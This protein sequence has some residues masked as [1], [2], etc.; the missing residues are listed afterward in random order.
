MPPGGGAE[1]IAVPHARSA[2]FIAIGASVALLAL[3][4]LAAPASAGNT[5]TLY[6][7]SP[8]A[9]GGTGG[10][11]T[12]T[13]GLLS[14]DL[15]AL[16]SVT[17]GGA[18]AVRVL[19]RN[20]GNQTLN[21]LAFIGG[22]LA[23]NAAYNTLYPKPT[24]NS[25]DSNLSF[26]AVYP[27][28]GA[29]TCA[30]VEPNEIR[31]NVGTL[32]SGDAAAYLVVIKTTSAASGALPFWLTASWNEG[33]STTGN[34]ADYAFAE[35]SVLVGAAS[36]SEVASY[37]LA[38]ANVNITNTVISGCAQQTTITTAPLG[39][40]GTFANIKVG[41]ATPCAAVGL[42]CFGNDSTVSVYG[43][44]AVAG[45]IEWTMRWE[46][47][48]INGKPKGVVHFLDAYYTGDSSAW[49]FISFNRQS[50]CKTTTSTDCWTKITSTKTYFEVTFRTAS[51]GGARGAY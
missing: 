9:D 29:P 27:L 4:T 7:G 30:T 40:V 28:D 37:F 1:V 39:G 17:A 21:K 23:D 14:G 15:V 33:W 51:N 35:G 19:L 20:D 26:L 12:A 41:G 16:N 25:L 45:G 50:E 49:V 8:E 3:A 42:R 34:N 38:N 48:Q 24:Y 47:L 10:G 44:Q 5:R 22:S 43:G 2:R 13:G 36:C 46:P 32:S 18:I 6:F 11:Y 31:C